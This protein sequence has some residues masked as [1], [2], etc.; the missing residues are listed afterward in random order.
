MHLKHLLS[1]LE[2]KSYTAGHV[3]CRVN[4]NPYSIEGGHVMFS[5]DD[6]EG[7]ISK[8]AVYEPTDLTKNSFQ[9]RKRR[10]Y[11]DWGWC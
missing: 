11:S 3:I 1:L 9:T 5:V 10:C 6:F 8:V 7:S 4:T 2:I